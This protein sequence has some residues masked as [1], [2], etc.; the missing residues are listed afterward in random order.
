LQAARIVSPAIER[1]VAMIHARS[2]GP[3]R[4]VSAVAR[5]L[6]KAIEQQADRGLW[7]VGGP[8]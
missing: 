5:L 7:R 4:A 1:I 8:D 2:K 6:V 3:S